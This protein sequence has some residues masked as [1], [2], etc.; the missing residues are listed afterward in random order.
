MEV[1]D[2]ARGSALRVLGS[3][4]LLSDQSSNLRGEVASFLQE[5]KVA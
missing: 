1:S 3:A 2:E 4:K 5:I